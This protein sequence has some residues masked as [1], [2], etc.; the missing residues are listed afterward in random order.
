M[1]VKE[2]CTVCDKWLTRGLLSRTNCGHLFHTSCVE[3]RLDDLC[4]RPGCDQESIDVEPVER[5][6]RKKHAQSD[7]R[8][9]VEAAARNDDWADLAKL[10][11]IA[12]NTAHSWV[13]LGRTSPI[14]PNR[15]Y[16]KKLT[17]EQIQLL[18][19]QVEEDSSISLK[20]M[21]QFVRRT[22]AINVSQSTIANYLNGHLYTM[23][24]MHKK[25]ANINSD[26]NVAQRKVYAD[27]LDNYI[28]QRKYLLKHIIISA[29]CD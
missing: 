14:I 28:R 21:R 1:V 13:R 15:R 26:V 6:K 2:K 10:L 9:I 17:N 18:L 11:G 27:Q 12:Y 23:K 4:P 3:S 5:K 22:M 7:R 24:M 8:R 16:T 19:N 25:C 29:V 20:R